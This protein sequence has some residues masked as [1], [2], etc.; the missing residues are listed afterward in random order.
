VLHSELHSAPWGCS[1][2]SSAAARRV[3]RAAR[4]ES[5]REGRR[6]FVAL[7]ACQR[8]SAFVLAWLCARAGT[9][10]CALPP[11]ALCPRR[12]AKGQR[13]RT[14]LQLTRL[15]A[16]LPSSSLFSSPSPFSRPPSPLFPPLSGGLML[17]H[18]VPDRATGPGHPA[19]P[20]KSQL[21]LFG[22][23]SPRSTPGRA[24]C[25]PTQGRQSL[26]A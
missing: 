8:S 20:A 24:G 25:R 15:L 4:R 10:L 14:C 9:A 22:R 12:I 21:A 13:P 23:H 18:P 6:R 19:R 26:A 1:S 3:R 7:H 5:V 17:P 11:R 16:P 2:T